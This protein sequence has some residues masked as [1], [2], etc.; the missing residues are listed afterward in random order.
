[1]TFYVTTARSKRT[2]SHYT[3]KQARECTKSKKNELVV[4]KSANLVFAFQSGK[5]DLKH[6]HRVTQVAD[7]DSIYMCSIKLQPVYG[8]SNSS[9]KFSDSAAHLS[10][11]SCAL[12]W[13]ERGCLCG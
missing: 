2:P 13:R 11:G 7:V 1:M 9:S 12:G 8:N 3:A 4:S 5:K 6:V 10:R